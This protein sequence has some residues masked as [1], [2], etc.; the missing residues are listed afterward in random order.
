MKPQQARNRF[1]KFIAYVLGYR[2]DEFGLVPD[3]NG[4]IKIK[5]LLKALSEEDGW[6]H[7]RRASFDELLLT[8]VNAPIEISGNL[9]RAADRTRLT[10][11]EITEQLPKLL[12]TCVRRK[13]YPHVCRKGIF[14]TANPQIVLASDQSMARRIGNRT[15][16]DPVLLT[17]QVHHSR[18]LGVVYYRAGGNLFLA[19]FVP[20]EGFTGPPLP[21][22]SP[23]DKKQPAAK[24]RR[25]Q[26]Q[27]GTFKLDPELFARKHGGKPG[28]R[29]RK[30]ADW[31]KDRKR[32][33]K[34]KN[35]LL[36]R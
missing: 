1:S 35:K 17:V 16:P 6:K 21:K 8:S 15:D 19:D 33:R 13:A 3:E 24:K 14:P 11:P 23:D 34:M 28:G 10:Q 29:R 26:D 2:P 9:I 25:E 12:Y 7:I 5:E 22:E 27:P 20:P 18:G 30:S 36:D 32:A 4:Y 31:K